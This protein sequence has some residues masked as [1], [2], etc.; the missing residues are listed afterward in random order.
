DEDRGVG[1]W[2]SS[3]R[4]SQ[5]TVTKK[6][7]NSYSKDGSVQ[8]TDEP[9]DGSQE[10]EVRASNRVRFVRPEMPVVPDP[11][12]EEQASSA[13]RRSILAPGDQSHFHNHPDPIPVSVSITPVLR[14]GDRL[15]V[16]DNGEPVEPGADGAI[17]LD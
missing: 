1:Q 3:A 15:E 13:Y 9:I 12:Q 10:I 6:L 17:Q 5:S 7:Y 14:E 2:P 11:E 8:F 16:T 4:W